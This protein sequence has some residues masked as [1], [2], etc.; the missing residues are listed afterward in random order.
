MYTSLAC[1][2]MIANDLCSKSCYQCNVDPKRFIQ[3]LC[4]DYIGDN[5]KWKLL[6]R[7]LG[8]T[9]SNTNHLAHL[10]HARV[11]AELIP[12]KLGVHAVM[13]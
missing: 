11:N 12:V 9:L 2:G 10:L 3:G 6:F 1:G 7:I 4:W 8:F 5:G 13:R